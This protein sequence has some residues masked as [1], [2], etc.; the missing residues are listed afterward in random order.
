MSRL[1]NSRSRAIGHSG[2]AMALFSGACSSDAGRQRL[3]EIAVGCGVSDLKVKQDR[4]NGRILLDEG[5]ISSPE[6]LP[7]ERQQAILSCI[8]PKA[9]EAGV[10]VDPNMV[11]GD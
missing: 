1:F 2:L 5:L 3:Q 7:S 9:S 4:H 11:M 6:V 10:E 8:V